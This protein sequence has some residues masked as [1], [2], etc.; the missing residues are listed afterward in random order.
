MFGNGV[1]FLSVVIATASLLASN[2]SVATPIS[3]D[4]MG[5]ASAYIFSDFKGNQNDSQNALLVGGNAVINAYTVGTLNPE[6]NLALLVQG[7]L[8]MTGGDVHGLANVGGTVSVTGTNALNLTDAQRNFDKAYF[9]NLSSQIAAQNSNAA[10]VEY[11]TLKLGGTLT[12]NTL[13]VNTSIADLSS[14]WG[15]FT[16]NIDFGTRIV[17]NVSGTQIDIDA[18]DWIVKNESYQGHSSENLLYNFYEASTINV[19]GGFYGSILA[20]NAD[21]IG[22]SGMIYGQLIADSFDGG[23]QLNRAIFNV[24][25]S[26]PQTGSVSVDSPSSFLLISLGMFLL[27]AFRRLKVA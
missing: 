5:D 18:K 11:G 16:Q 24:D 13:F 10:L 4:D 7:N 1:S 15:L 17:V 27:A 23:T 22:K 12:E 3:F 20:P 14:V 9:Q 19:A 8:T 2:V 6:N 26:A 25:P 21:V